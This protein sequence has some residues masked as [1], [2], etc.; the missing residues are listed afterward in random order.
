MILGHPAEK[1]EKRRLAELS[2]LQG[3]KR[4]KQPHTVMAKTSHTM[5]PILPIITTMVGM[6]NAVNTF[7][8]H[9]VYSNVED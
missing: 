6:P 2:L 8:I 5:L 1:K 7:N 9:A 3:T 4:Q